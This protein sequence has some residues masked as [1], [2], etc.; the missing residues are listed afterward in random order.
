MKINLLIV[1]AFF[2]LIG[3]GQQGYKMYGKVTDSKS[4]EALAGATIYCTD[5]KNMAVADEQGNYKLTGISAGHHVIEISFTGYGTLVEHIEIVSDT[6]K[7]FSLSHV[8]IENQ[9][10]IVTGVSGPVN[11]KKTP[12]PL[13]VIKKNMMLQSPSANL[14]DALSKVPGVSQLS[15][16]Q[17]V[18]KPIIRGLGYNRVVTVNDGV[19]Q[20]GQQWGD[21][22]GIE[23]DELSVSKVEVLKGPASLMYGSDALAGVVNFITNVPVAQGLIKGNLLT[24]YQTNSRLTA[25]NASIAGNKNGFNWNVYATVKSAG[26]YKNKYDGRVLNSRFNEKNFGGYLGVNKSWGYSHLI[27]SHFGQNLGMV[28]GDRDDATGKFILFAGTPIERIA[29]D[30]D[31]NG[32]QLFTPKQRVQ[33]TK[34]V[35]DNNFVLGKSRLKLNIG[36]QSNIRKEFGNAEDPSEEELFFDL[37]TINYNL[38]WQLPEAKEWHTT[39]GVN[40]MGQGNKNKGAETLI[41]AYNLFD[42]GLFVHTQRYFKKATLSGG[43]RFD[44]RTIKGKELVESG[45]VK[46]PAF[47]K[48]FSNLS[49][50]VGISYEAA[51]AIILKANIARGFRAPSLAELSSNGTHEGT[52]RYEY[53]SLDLKSETSL[54]FDGG[55]DIN[56][57]HLNIGISAFHNSI[58]DFI[59]YRKLESVSGGDSLM[60]IDGE[61]VTAFKFN[62]NNAKLYGLEIF[63]DFHP[64]PLDWLHFE[65]SFSIVRGRFNTKIDGNLTGS[66]NL[67]LMPAPRWIGE[68]RGDFKKAGKGLQQ[69]YVKLTADNTFRQNRYF[70]GFDTETATSGYTLLNAGAGADVLN[71]KRKTIFSFHFAVVNLTDKAWQSHLSRLKYTATNLVTGRQGVFNPG[72]NFSLKL[73]IPLEYKIK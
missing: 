43:I 72:R 20:E 35:T 62:Q 28:E 15:S 40:G 38:Q 44:N 49:G 31:L 45:D 52:N 57:D 39:I 37:S 60:S 18:S 36:Y 51:D 24:N 11:I 21:E 73:N 2:P 65:N 47:R 25:T 46:F 41:P 66:D 27:F 50:S 56:Y 22:H 55:I 63:F 5:D 1:F 53:G 6:E 16:G 13:S 68:I 3:I 61:D 10:V 30:G 69:L 64:H 70:T 54:Q 9:E 58:N 12:V 17:S 26:D 4:G 33:H 32:R 48:S 67:P 59:F 42:A 19:R 14:V 71:S 8:I 29:T 23:I 34:L 7:N